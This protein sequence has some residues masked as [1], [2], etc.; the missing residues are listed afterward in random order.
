MGYTFFFDDYLDDL[1][2]KAKKEKKIKDFKTWNHLPMEIELESLNKLDAVHQGI[3]EYYEKRSDGFEL[4]WWS[5]KEK[6]LGG[7]MNLAETE[8]LF[9]DMKAYYDEEIL[10]V[11]GEDLQYFQPF[12]YCSN[13]SRCGFI[14]RPD[15]IEKSMYYKSVD[16]YELDYLD[17]DYHGYTQMAIEA[18]VFYDWQVV[19]L[20]YM[21][22]VGIG[23]VE[24]ETFKT[25]M[26][27]IFPDWT[28]ENF[29]AKFESLRLSNKEK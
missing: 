23:S 15:S 22:G 9:A 21:N 29:I 26:P 12:D 16:D 2:L 24:T 10:S 17:L 25:E 28:W 27:K 19:L 13:E 14:I 1:L 20:Y 6:S 8:Y 11:H 7:K 5:N 3:K 4:E 18:R